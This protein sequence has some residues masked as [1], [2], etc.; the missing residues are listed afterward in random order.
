[1]VGR[2]EV[3]APLPE[4]ASLREVKWRTIFGEERVASQGVDEDGN[5]LCKMCQSI[6]RCGQNFLEGKVC[7]KGEEK[8]RSPFLQELLKCLQ[9]NRREQT[10][11]KPQFVRDQEKL[12]CS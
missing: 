3:G 9:V 1:V 2:D 11:W 5:P 10:S 12:L 8:F 4:G 6:C 7:R